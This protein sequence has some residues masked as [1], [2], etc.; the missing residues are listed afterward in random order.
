MTPEQ[1]KIVED[2]ANNRYLPPEQMAAYRAVL[3]EVDARQVTLSVLD[4]SLRDRDDELRLLRVALQAIWPYIQ[5]DEC[6]ELDPGYR[7]AIEL[8]R[9]QVEVMA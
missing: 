3:G 1:R 8:C 2:A 4:L 5:E 6:L 7:N 9:A